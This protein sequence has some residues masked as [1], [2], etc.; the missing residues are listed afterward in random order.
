MRAGAPYPFVRLHRRQADYLGAHRRR[1]G[2]QALPEISGAGCA[3]LDY[4][5][6]AGWIYLVSSG[7]ADFYL[8]EAADV[9]CVT[10]AWHG[11]RCDGEERAWAAAWNGSCGRGLR[12]RLP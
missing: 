10:I 9:R 3:F 8:L 7:Q 2:A 6:M 11:Y 4:A 1:V 12:R 5:T